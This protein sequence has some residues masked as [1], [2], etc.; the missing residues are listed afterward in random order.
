MDI[1][2]N[3]QRK[4]L[5]KRCFLVCGLAVFAFLQ[6]SLLNASKPG[7]DDMKIN[8][9]EDKPIRISKKS[10]S[11]SECESLCGGCEVK[12]KAPGVDVEASV[13]KS[14]IRFETE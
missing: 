7:E 3:N 5:K 11:K 14:K 6:V 1:I 12:V 8:E 2:N 9:P 4:N 13:K 10:Q